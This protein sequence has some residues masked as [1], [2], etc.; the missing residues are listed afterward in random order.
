MIQR[1][2]L[3]LTI[4]L[5]LTTMSTSLETNAQE[6]KIG[7]VDPQSILISMP[8][9][10]AVDQRLQNFAARKQQ[11]LVQKQQAFQNEVVAYQQKIGVISA[12]AQRQEE[13]RLAQLESDLLQAQQ[14][15]EQEV[16]AKRNE[17]V[18]PLYKQIG[19][20]INA[21]ATRKEL[22]YV[23]NTRTSSG[24]FVVLYASDEYQAKYNITEDVMEE[25]GMFN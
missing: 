17:L 1:K 18:G 6:L 2:H 24:D 25:L 5:F 7:Y 15:A 22:I 20:A 11:E 16:E 9:M 8:E 12:D 4:A 21:V 13:E 23:L 19:D 3:L 14:I 10:K